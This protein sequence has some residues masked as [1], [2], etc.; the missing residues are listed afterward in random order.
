M[1]QGKLNEKDTFKIKMHDGV[2]QIL[3]NLRF[4]SHLR[5]SLSSLSKHDSLGYG[6]F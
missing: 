5:K 6:F 1:N 3:N 2:I 4:V